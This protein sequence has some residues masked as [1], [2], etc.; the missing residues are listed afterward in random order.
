VGDGDEAHAGRAQDHGGDR[1]RD[2]GA[3]GA[4]LAAVALLAVFA[5][6]FLLL[7]VLPFWDSLRRRV[8]VWR[9]PPWPV[10]AL[11]AATTALAGV[12]AM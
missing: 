10:V 9:L 8:A 1:R 5:P 11:G 3:A 6:S 4:G 2:D 7:G 12:L